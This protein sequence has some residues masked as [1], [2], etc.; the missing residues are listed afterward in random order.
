MNIPQFLGTM[1]LKYDNW[2]YYTSKSGE[3]Q[4]SCSLFIFNLYK[5]FVIGP[6][7]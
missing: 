6:K 5:I 7:V 2:E 4:E 1:I 3:L